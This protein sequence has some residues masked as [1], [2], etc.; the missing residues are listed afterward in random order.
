MEFS[1]TLRSFLFCFV[2]KFFVQS[3]LQNSVCSSSLPSH[4]RPQKT[5]TPGNVGK[6]GGGQGH[7]REEGK[8]LQ[9]PMK[10]I[11]EPCQDVYLSLQQWKGIRG[12]R[13]RHDTTKQ[14]QNKKQDKLSFGTMVLADCRKYSKMINLLLNSTQYL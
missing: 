6:R 9:K 13:Q 7:V 12:R 14:K 3:N 11:T 1:T 8:Q 10:Q 5:F 2:F 4:S